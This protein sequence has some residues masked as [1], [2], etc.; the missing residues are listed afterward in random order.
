MDV[1]IV[2]DSHWETGLTK[3]SSKLSER[4]AVFFENKHYGDSLSRVGIVLMCRDP[5]LEFKQR[6]RRSKKDAILYLD[7]MLDY[8]EMTDLGHTEQM[9]V[10]S[11][12]VVREVGSALAKYK[13]EDFDKESFMA[14]VSKCLGKTTPQSTSRGAA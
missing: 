1:R 5:L 10:V 2:S 7:V 3:V 11:D 6:I 9:N 14:D 13:F 12:H 8:D 4:T